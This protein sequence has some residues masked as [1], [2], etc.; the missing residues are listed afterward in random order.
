MNGDKSWNAMNCF[1]SFH[2]RIRI[3]MTYENPKHI[4]NKYNLLDPDFIRE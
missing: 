1:A 2:G 4:L 3:E